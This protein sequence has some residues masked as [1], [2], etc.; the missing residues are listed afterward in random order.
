MRDFSFR[1]AEAEARSDA[2]LPVW[3]A[4]LALGIGFLLGLLLSTA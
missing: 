2:R 4:L 1:I 3:S